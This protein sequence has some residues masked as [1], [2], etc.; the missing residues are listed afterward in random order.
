MNNYRSIVEGLK[1]RF[2]NEEEMAEIAEYG[3]QAL[4]LDELSDPWSSS[5]FRFA[6]Y[7]A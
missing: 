7:P 3:K 2:V 6:F 5:I 4:Y 1:S